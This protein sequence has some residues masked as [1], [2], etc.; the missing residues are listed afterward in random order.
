[1]SSVPLSSSIKHGVAAYRRGCRCNLCREAK[2]LAQ[3]R[4][5]ARRKA[6]GRPVDYSA[7]RQ[8]EQRTCVH[9]SAPFAVRTDAPNRF[10]SLDCANIAQ[11]WNPCK[12]LV[13]VGP[14]QHMRPTTAPV[15]IVTSGRYWGAITNGPCSWCGSAFTALSASALYCSRRCARNAGKARRGRFTLPDSVRREIYERDDWTCQ[16]CLEPVDPAADPNSDWYPTLDHIVPQ[17]HQLIPDQSPEA[18][19]T[20]HRWCNA[21][22]GDLTHYTDADLIA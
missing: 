11:G 21:V 16:I 22:R 4:W 13:Y 18:L 6:T 5:V 7:Y 2:R 1:M 10:C 19:R 8:V 9:C 17:S 15:T 20:A 3:Q 14:V 12:A